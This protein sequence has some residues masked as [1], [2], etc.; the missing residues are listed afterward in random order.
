MS[1]GTLL[2]EVI[3]GIF[4]RITKS[5]GEHYITSR[6]VK[7]VNEGREISGSY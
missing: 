1:N 2:N 4:G 7:K 5:V 3:F 6:N